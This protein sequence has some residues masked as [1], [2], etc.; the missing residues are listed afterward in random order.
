MSYPPGVRK[1]HAAQ[2]RMT[3]ALKKAYGVTD[4]DLAVEDK[5][6][7]VIVL[8]FGK[9]NYV[10]VVVQVKTDVPLT[11]KSIRE[12]I[13]IA[14]A[15]RHSYDQKKFDAGFIHDHDI[16]SM[17]HAV[18]SG[19]FGFVPPKLPVFTHLRVEGYL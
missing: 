7:G 11:P 16:G 10:P 4:E 5:S 17:I 6:L 9:G 14:F 15:W 12:M 8:E 13:R 3:A 1:F 19:A 18:F 2:A